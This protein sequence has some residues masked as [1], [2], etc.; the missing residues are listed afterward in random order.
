MDINELIKIIR[1][2][3]AEIIEENGSIVYSSVDTIRKSDIYTL[4]LNPGGEE[5]NTIDHSLNELPVRH[6]NAYIDEDWSNRKKSDYINGQHP[7]QKNFN[8][9][10]TN[11]GYETKNVFSSNLI[12]TR[13]SGQKGAHYPKN[14][15]ICWKVHKE[16]IKII[17]PKIFIVFGISK[18]SPFQY[19]KN[20]YKLEINESIDSGHG[21]WKC[22]SCI[23][24]IENKERILIGV[25]HLSRYYIMRHEDKN[26]I[27][28]IISQFNIFKY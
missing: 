23:G 22:F 1:S 2:H 13:S 6:V 19:I 24:K 8:A 16:F 10:I 9:L 14:A 11:I 7:L 15:D 21:K 25:P 12:F 17:D 5:N 26:V 18:I 28:W 20:E 3:L 27:K 4:G